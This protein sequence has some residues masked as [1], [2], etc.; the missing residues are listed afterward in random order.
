M[1]AFRLKLVDAHPGDIRVPY[2]YSTIQ[3]AINVANPGDVIHVVAVPTRI[4][5]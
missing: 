5:L 4:L 3:A 1:F 2:D